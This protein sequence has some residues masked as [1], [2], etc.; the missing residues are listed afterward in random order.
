MGLSPL[1]IGPCADRELFR[2]ET[3]SVNIFF[4]IVQL[5]QLI[6]GFIFSFD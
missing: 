3:L 4:F 1:W 6:F 2:Q 5:L